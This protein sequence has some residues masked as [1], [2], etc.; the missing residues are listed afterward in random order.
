MTTLHTSLK[1]I[2]SS[3]SYSSTTSAPATPDSANVTAA[4]LK[5]VAEKAKALKTLS[6]QLMHIQPGS[7][8]LDV[9]CGPAVDTLSLQQQVGH[10]GLAVGVDLD[11]GMLAEALKLQPTT[12]APAY[13]H[14]GVPQLPF[15]A[16]AFD[17]VRAERLLQVLPATIDLQVVVAEIA[18]ITK[19]GGRVVLVDTDWGSLSFA[20]NDNALERTLS[21]FFASELR[22]NGFAGRDLLRFAN[23]PN[24]KEIELNVQPIVHRS[25]DQ[26]PINWLVKEAK[27][28]NL[29]AHE[30]IENWQQSLQSA[31]DRGEFMATVNMVIL[32]CEAV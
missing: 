23:L 16:G 14:A 26:L 6:H 7:L 2:D 19:S 20:S 11:A 30:T 27:A 8:V 28:R 24:L 18:R 31:Q 22:P 5:R 10:Q 12:H 25:L 32:A 21:Q 3:T 17:A 4:Y 29:A 13:V 9:G 1:P 15:K